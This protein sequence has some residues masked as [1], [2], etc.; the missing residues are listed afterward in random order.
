[1]DKKIEI[2]L[3]AVEQV[4]VG[5]GRCFVINGHDVAVF[6]SRRGNLSAI[7]NRCPHRGGPLA[8]GIMGEDLVVCPLHG[9]K[10]NLKTG[11]GNDGHECV[12]TFFVCE[13]EGNIVLEYPASLLR[14][15]SRIG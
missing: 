5:Q 9:H 14:F 13:R 7:E 8:D 2:N 6:R 15:S 12:Q 1:M 11:R 10:F 3:G 4:A